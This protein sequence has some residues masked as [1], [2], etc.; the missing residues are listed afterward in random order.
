MLTKLTDE[1]NETYGG[2]RWVPGEWREDTG[3]G[4]L[5]G[6]GWLHYYDDPLLAELHNPI[7]AKIASPLFWRCEVGGETL[8]DGQVKAGA[9]RLRIV[10][11]IER[12]IVT[13]PQ[14]VRYAIYCAQAVGGGGDVWD[15]WA[16]AWLS[17]E[18]RSAAAAVRT[19][20]WAQAAALPAKEAAQAAAHAEKAA[21]QA[22][23]AWLAAV[24]AAT[25]GGDLDLLAIAKRAIRDETGAEPQGE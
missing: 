15:R 10:E 11:R 8:R 4:D 1:N 18:D 19:A 22:A 6:P 17:G 2:T 9:T 20:A 24:A 12:P 7:H 3:E 5:C 21:W 14:R 25:A 23:R 16:A 13:I